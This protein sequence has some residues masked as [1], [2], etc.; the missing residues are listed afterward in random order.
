[1]S[2]TARSPSL[3]LRRRTVVNISVMSRLTGLL[4]FLVLLTGGCAMDDGVL[5]CVQDEDGLNCTNDSLRTSGTFSPE[6]SRGDYSE[7]RAYRDCALGVMIAD[8][9]VSEAD[10]YAACVAEGRL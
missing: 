8:P 1:M 4:L 3:A 6:S 2:A 10:A 7:L 5:G 9:D